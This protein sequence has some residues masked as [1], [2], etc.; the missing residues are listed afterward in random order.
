MFTGI[1]EEVGTLRAIH[2]GSQSAQLQIAATNVRAGTRVGDSILTDGT[3]LTVTALSAVGFTADAMP[4]TMRR[5]TLGM[6]RPGD[7][8]NLER[9]LRAD[10]LLGG[11]LVTGHVDGVGSVRALESEGNALVLT[12]AAPA[13]VTRLSVPRG[14]VAVNGASLTVVDSSPDSIRVALIPHTAA[15]TNLGEL[16]P[17]ATVNLEADVI[18]RYVA[19]LLQRMIGGDGDE[20]ASS[21]RRQPSG[22]GL[23]WE[24]LG[25]SG[26][27]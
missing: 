19:T 21:S 17:G 16:K 14:S 20:R 22:G 24:K 3:C 15:V 25:E 9:S 1:V 18:A 11:H 4:E 23:T 12:I 13:E 26:F 27:L 7:R 2:V 5:T 8:L 6:R 10:S